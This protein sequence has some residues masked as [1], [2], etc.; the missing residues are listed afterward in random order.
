MPIYYALMNN[1]YKLAFT[2]HVHDVGMPV[3]RV[4]NRK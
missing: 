4:R 2:N 1:D 3:R